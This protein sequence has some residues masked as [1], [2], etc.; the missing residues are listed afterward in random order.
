MGADGGTGR[1]RAVLFADD[2]HHIL[3]DGD[4][5][6]LEADTGD[7]GDDVHSV[8]RLE[9]IDRRDAFPGDQWPMSGPL[10]REVFEETLDLTCQH[11]LGIGDWG[12]SHVSI[13]RASAEGKGNPEAVSVLNLYECYRLRLYY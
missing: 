6:C 1:G 7:I 4:P 12:T 9:D 2:D 11:G 13:V 3:D 5:Q 8:G 10:L